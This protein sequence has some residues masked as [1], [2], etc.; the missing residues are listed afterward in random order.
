MKFFFLSALFF[1]IACNP[2]FAEVGADKNDVVKYFKLTKTSDPKSLGEGVLIMASAG[3]KRIVT[4]YLKNERG[5]AHTDVTISTLN[6]FHLDSVYSQTEA[7]KLQP[8]FDQPD[9]YNSLRIG[10]EVR[11]YKLEILPREEAMAMITQLSC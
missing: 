2:Q 7:C 10:G 6:G 8:D 4:Y 1:V 3:D 11:G 5:F 9:I